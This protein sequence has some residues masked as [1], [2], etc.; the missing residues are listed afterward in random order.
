MFYH[1][2]RL[3]SI[4]IAVLFNSILFILFF[5][6]TKRSFVRLPRKKYTERDIFLNSIRPHTI[7]PMTTFEKSIVFFIR[8]KLHINF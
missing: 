5:F 1:V 2:D 4:D 6:T 3:M 7:S 8:Y